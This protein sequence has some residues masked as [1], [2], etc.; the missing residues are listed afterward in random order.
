MSKK[1][2]GS[3]RSTVLIGAFAALTA[4]IS[5]LSVPLPSGV[6]ATLQ[7]FAAAL[8]GYALGRRDGALAVAVYLLLGAVGL[9]VFAGFRGGIG[10]LFGVTGGFLFGFLP[11]S[12]LCREK[13]PWLGALGLL[14]CH[15]AGT[16]QFAAVSGATP[17]QAFAVASLPFLAKDAALVAFAFFAAKAVRKG[18]RSA[19]R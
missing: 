9:P 12:W 1:N 13:A 6:P 10:T 11:L 4:V 17:A 2:G 18:V 8:C 16:A 19:G 3:A 5:Q 15:A 14:A 7:T